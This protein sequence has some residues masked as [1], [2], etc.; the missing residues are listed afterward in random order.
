MFEFPRHQRR[1]GSR[2]T[3][4]LVVIVR[5]VAVGRITRGVIQMELPSSSAC[6]V[7]GYCR[8]EPGGFAWGHKSVADMRNDLRCADVPL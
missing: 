2:V 6:G 8:R 1:E 4:Y 3:F 5:K 7:A